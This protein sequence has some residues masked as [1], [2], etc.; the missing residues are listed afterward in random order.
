MSVLPEKDISNVVVQYKY[1]SIKNC[2]GL[3]VKVQKRWV[4][5]ENP[6]IIQSKQYLQRTGI[7]DGKIWKS[8]DRDGNIAAEKNE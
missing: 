2:R 6:N 4:Y 5:F 3:C 1:Y 7:Q 8:G